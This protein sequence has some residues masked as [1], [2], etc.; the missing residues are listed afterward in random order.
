MRD[1][2]MCAWIEVEKDQSRTGTVLSYSSNSTAN[3]LVLDVDN[4]K[5]R[6]YTQTQTPYSLTLQSLQSSQKV[7]ISLLKQTP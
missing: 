4:S 7:N 3:E 5:T 2:S 6:V 1:L